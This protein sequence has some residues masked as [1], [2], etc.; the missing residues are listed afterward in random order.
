METAIQKLT[1]E[2]KII[3][4]VKETMSDLVT[5]EELN[6]YASKAIKEAIT[7]TIKGYTSDYRNPIKDAS[8]R[9]V[10]TLL[11]D[12]REDEEIRQLINE[13]FVR[14]LP[15]LL[16]DLMRNGFKQ[17]MEYNSYD[18]ETRIMDRLSR[19]RF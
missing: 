1:L 9:I 12:I 19:H 13:L 7:D 3:A 14:N 17:V 18:V 11:E 10:T 5:D 16:M 8:N 2:Q 15:Y 6:E 4:K